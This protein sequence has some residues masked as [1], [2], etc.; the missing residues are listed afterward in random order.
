MTMTNA[1]NPYT[2]NLNG[3]LAVG[4]TVYLYLTGHIGNNQSCVGN[5][6]NNIDLRYMVNGQLKT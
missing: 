2:W 4:Q 3:S 6:I 1:N 5:Y